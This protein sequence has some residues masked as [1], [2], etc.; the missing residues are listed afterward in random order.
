M[1]LRGYLDSQTD[2]S[3]FDEARDNED[4]LAFM[5]K[6]SMRVGG[7]ELLYDRAPNFSRLLRCQ[8]SQYLTFVA[9]NKQKKIL[10]FF[11]ISTTQKWVYGRKVVCGYI[12]DFRTDNSRQS[13]LL[14]RRSYARILGAVQNEKSLGA[15]SYFLTAI[16]KNNLEAVRSLATSKRDFGFQYNFL[17]DVEMVNVYGFLPL[18]K[19]PQLNVEQAKPEDLL[20]LKKFLNQNEKNKMFGSIFDDSEADAWAYREKTWNDFSVDQ[21]LLIRNKE[22]EIVACTLPW[23][24][25]GAKRM[26]VLRA[27]WVLR[28]VFRGLAFCRFNTP[29]VGESLRT[30]YLTHLNIAEGIKKD[31]VIRAFLAWVFQTHRSV[32]MVSFSDDTGFSKGMR[33]CISQRIPVALYAVTLGGDASF[34]APLNVG[35]EMGLV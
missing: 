32:H 34:T 10:G 14:W 33:S 17:Q 23:D 9:R 28:A 26:K 4:L 19:K 24:P 22:R 13:A 7:I 18:V 3:Q 12:G 16:L 35:F 8:G 2:I 30:T 31:E 21:F 25:G 6:S 29:K 1:D 27:P 5:E 11:S 15:P 20:A